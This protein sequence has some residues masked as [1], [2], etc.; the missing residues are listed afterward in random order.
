MASRRC[1]AVAVLAIIRRTVWLRN[2][3]TS[4]SRTMMRM[5]PCCKSAIPNGGADQPMSTWPVIV[6]VKVEDGLPVAI[7][8]ACAPN[9]R[10]NASTARLVDEP[11]V[12]YAMVLPLASLMLLMGDAAGTYQNRS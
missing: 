12:E 1:S 10:L 2:A 7:G 9:S 4:L 3:G 6:W 5:R 11:L 8:L